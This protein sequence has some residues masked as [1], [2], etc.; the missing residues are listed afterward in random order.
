MKAYWVEY[1]L[2]GVHEE[3]KGLQVIAKNK[4]DAYDKA[5]YEI[6][7]EKEGRVPYSAWV[8]SV[9]YNNGN[10]KEFNTSSGNPY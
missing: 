7:P 5:T 8:S 9:T 3:A 6:I 2:N 1:Y 4:V 10:Y